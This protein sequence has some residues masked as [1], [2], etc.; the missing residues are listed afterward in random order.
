[1]FQAFASCPKYIE[2]LLK[3]ELLALG[4]EIVE[5][6]LAGVSFKAD[7]KILLEVVMWSRLANR[8]MIH[9]L[10]DSIRNKDDLYNAIASIDWVPLTHQPA[11]S[12]HIRFQGTT[13]QL[14]NTLFSQ[15]VCKDAIC[16][17]YQRTGRLR[18]NVVKT[19]AQ[20]NVYARLKHKQLNVYLDIT[21]Q[22][23]HQRGYR[24]DRTAAPLRENLAAA[25]LLRANWSELSQ[26]NHN[27]IDPMC[28]SGTLLT[29]GW[30]MA[31]DVAPNSALESSGLSAW[32]GYDADH[33]AQLQSDAEQRKEQG[34]ATF[35]GQIIG[36]DH[37]QDSIHKAQKNIDR[38]GAEGKIQCQMQTL[39]KFRIP[40]RNNLVICN[41]PYGVRLQKNS[42]RSW[43]ALAHW[44]SRY[45]MG[46]E[47]AIVTPDA[48]NGF[49][50]G[51]R[52]Y[53]VW[54]FM[55]G[56][57]DIQLRQFHL[58]KDQQLEAHQDQFFALP[59]SAQMLANRLKKNK[60]ER[61]ARMQEHNIEAWRLYDAELPE[62]AVAIDVYG[63]MIHLQEY[64]APKSIP[65]KKARQR[66][67][68]ARLAVQAVMQPDLNKIS[69]KT[70]QKQ[71]G[72]SQY[73][74]LD[75]KHDQQQVVQEKGR[76]YIVNL[77]RY[78]DTGLFLDHRW[79]RDQIQSLSKDKTVL[80]LFGYTG[81]IAVAA[82]LGGAA[83]AV[84]VDTS[85]TYLKWAEDNFNLNHIN[86]NRYQNV[87]ADVLEYVTTTQDRFDLIVADPPTFSNSHSRERDWDV[88]RDHVELIEACG[89]LLKP[90]GTLFFSNNFKK[91]SLDDSLK[92]QFTIEDIS[93]ES[94]DVDF[95][96]SHKI[97]WCYKM[98]LKD[99]VRDV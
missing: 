25:L 1:M 35:R 16:D 74:A 92:Q 68:L 24:I 45:A 12:L 82:A 39:E 69:I 18:P 66:L 88:Q 38:L 26:Q 9:L 32:K 2:L 91:F 7:A 53:K 89:R 13:P 54:S 47:A 73:L 96:S 49:M 43:Y 83:Q 6:K 21:G 27:L 79:L 31:C 52:E 72:K 62:F 15:Q 85:K 98:Q 60:K 3:E 80:N 5:E 95:R 44:L 77:F 84:N 14:K 36:V 4:C 8:I 99:G 81:S 19:Q 40:P 23:L 17:Q 78:L 57:L 64:Q 55:N 46:A 34:M 48:S 97:H 75:Q 58:R 41:P 33:W 86:S 70:R 42:T 29:E 59:A 94:L 61:Q 76:Q 63:D 71:K 56:A 20:L 51:F 93:R 50:L 10:E 30:M 65:E 87:R 37:H 28:G 67:F 90:G 22:S 11:E